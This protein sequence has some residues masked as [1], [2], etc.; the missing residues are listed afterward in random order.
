MTSQLTSR[1]REKVKMGQTERGLPR[2]D[3]S[4]SPQVNKFGTVWNG[5]YDFLLV[6]NSNSLA[7]SHGLR[8]MS[9]QIQNFMRPWES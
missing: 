7:I 1:D 4:T 2:F 9:D 6:N 5:A 8:D 3:L